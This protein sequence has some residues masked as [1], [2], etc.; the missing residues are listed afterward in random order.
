M[1]RPGPNARPRRVS[2]HAFTGQKYGRGRA[3]RVV[4]ARREKRER[5]SSP[6]SACEELIGTLTDSEP[7]NMS[8]PSGERNGLEEKR[9]NS[10]ALKILDSLVLKILRMPC[11]EPAEP[12]GAEHLWRKAAVSPRSHK[13]FVLCEGREDEHGFFRASLGCRGAGSRRRGTPAPSASPRGKCGR[14]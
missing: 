2:T 1:S 14:A 11:E 4:K 10:L 6:G 12:R 9:R 8:H 7:R 13:R 5:W 3:R